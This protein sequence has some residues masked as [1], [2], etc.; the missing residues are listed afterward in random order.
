[1]P[2]IVSRIA[3]GTRQIIQLGMILKFRK[4]MSN[5]LVAICDNLKWNSVFFIHFL[6]SILYPEDW[7]TLI[8]KMSLPIFG[9]Q[10]QIFY[11]FLQLKD[12]DLLLAG[13]WVHVHWQPHNSQNGGSGFKH[14]A[15]IQ[16]W[17]PFRKGTH[18][19]LT[20]SLLH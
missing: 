1:M 4:R 7:L 19:C 13:A 9:Y 6:A 8:I 15:A 3:K 17:A 14:W 2:I 20:K 11:F 18:T 12:G 10:N 16:E 5:I